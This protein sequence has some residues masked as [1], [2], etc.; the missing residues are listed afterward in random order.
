M[1]QELPKP[2]EV[3]DAFQQALHEWN[4]DVSRPYVPTQHITDRAM[5]ILY[6]KE[7]IHETA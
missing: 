6:R 2:R 4:E 7:A 5:E 3:I 1:T